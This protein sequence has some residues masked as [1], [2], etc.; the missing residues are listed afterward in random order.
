MIPCIYSS[1]DQVNNKKPSKN[2]NKKIRYT[3]T[4]LEVGSVPTWGRRVGRRR[5]RDLWVLEMLCFLIS[6]LVTWIQGTGENYVPL[7]G[8]L[9][10]NETF[11]L[12]KNGIVETEPQR[13]EGGE[14]A[15][16][17]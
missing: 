3:N 4:Q 10:F 16:E 7:Y 14:A 5:E 1:K 15:L 11:T 13:E 8:M 6:S 2:Q 17:A 12:K 9:L